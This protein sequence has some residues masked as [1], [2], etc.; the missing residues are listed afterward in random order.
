M[1]VLT[2]KSGETINIG[3]GVVVRVISCNRGRVK[4]GFEADRS[5]RIWRG[6]LTDDGNSPQSEPEPV[7]DTA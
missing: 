7:A 2:R 6:E 1:L 4:L 5:V 3:D